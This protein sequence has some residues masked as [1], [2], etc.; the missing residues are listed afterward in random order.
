MKRRIREYILWT[1]QSVSGTIG[2]IS[3]R[4][5]DNDDEESDYY[6]LTF[7]IDFQHDNDTVYFAH[8]YPY[9]YSD[10]QV[11]DNICICCF[12]RLSF[13]RT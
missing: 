4:S 13:L 5:V 10:L 7:N 11:C 9:T 12:H 1:H 2:I 3:C 6:T 8:S